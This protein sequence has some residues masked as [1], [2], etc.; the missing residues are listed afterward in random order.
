MFDI[1]IRSIPDEAAAELKRQAAILGLNLEAY[2]RMCLVQKARDNERLGFQIK[3]K[4][5][6]PV[7]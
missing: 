2:M 5:S 1:R 6:V 3:R 4:P 7:K